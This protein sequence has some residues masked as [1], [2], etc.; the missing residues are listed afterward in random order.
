MATLPH[1]TQTTHQT[2]ASRWLIRVVA[3][4]VI[5]IAIS[6]TLGAL[7]VGF[8][9]RWG[10][11]RIGNFTDGSDA[12]V[13]G[14]LI[15]AVTVFVA[16]A[17]V[18][19]S[20]LSWGRRGGPGL[21]ILAA[22]FGLLFMVPIGVTL[23]IYFEFGGNSSHSAQRTIEIEAPGFDTG[24]VLGGVLATAG[25]VALALA[26]GS[27][28][29]KVFGDKRAPVGHA[30]GAPIGYTDAGEPIYQQVGYSADG[31]P[32]FGNQ[33]QGPLARPGQTNTLA[34]VALVLGVVSGL[35][36]IPFGHVAL[37]QI[38]RT[39]EQGRGMAIAGLVLGYLS[40][41]AIVALAVFV[42]VAI[43]G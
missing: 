24:F 17:S 7:P 3:S 9:L 40:L 27:R 21:S 6:L 29:R 13:L 18:L 10:A 5:A 41:A 22:V 32:V 20:S 42:F 36:A 28:I 15:G 2:S 23:A 39:G 38:R 33:V 26:L 31:R 30:G 4:L 19:V 1:L 43:N 25:Y 12:T 37:S 16:S 34:V 14:V 8:L 11:L 35:L